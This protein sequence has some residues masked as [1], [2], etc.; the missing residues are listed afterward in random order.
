MSLKKIC[1]LLFI[2]TAVTVK[3]PALDPPYRMPPFFP[4]LLSKRVKD[5]ISFVCRIVQTNTFKKEIFVFI[6][7]EGGLPLIT[8]LCDSEF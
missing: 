2:Y 4:C 5:M 1:F 7:F 3:D 8:E 6:E